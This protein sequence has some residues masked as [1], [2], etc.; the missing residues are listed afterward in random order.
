[1]RRNYST[2]K[3]KPTIVIT[4]PVE[5]ESTSLDRRRKNRLTTSIEQKNVGNIGGFMIT[6]TGMSKP[7]LSPKVSFA[8]SQPKSINNPCYEIQFEDIDM[9]I[10]N[11]I[12]KLT[13]NVKENNLKS[14]KEMVLNSFK[15]MN[16]KK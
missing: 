16:Y 9:N 13:S 14:V 12:Q 6:Q 3:K 4:K 8:E 5:Q 2:I 15:N 1:M 11:A 7:V 10:N